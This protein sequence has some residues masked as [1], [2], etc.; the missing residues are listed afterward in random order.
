MG[1]GT[2]DL[3][4][5]LRV[6]HALTSINEGVKF[7]RQITGKLNRCKLRQLVAIL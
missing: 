4:L 3:T 2:T 6:R 1:T 7:D 5:R